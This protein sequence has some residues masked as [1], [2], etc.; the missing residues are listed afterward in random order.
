M[1]D[2]LRKA[3]WAVP[4]LTEDQLQR[5][6]RRAHQKAAARRAR[7]RQAAAAVRLAAAGA[8]AALVL[9]QQTSFDREL[10]SARAMLAAEIARARE[11][12]VLAIHD[13]QERHREEASHEERSIR[14]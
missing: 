10:S 12:T 1:N 5:V 2:D 11:E 4:E 13:L 3:A 9:V 8:I 6:T 14:D 7:R